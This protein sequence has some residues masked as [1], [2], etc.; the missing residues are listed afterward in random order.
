VWRGLG[1]VR[2]GRLL[3]DVMVD[4]IWFPDECW[5][6]AE[7]LLIM[8][9]SRLWNEGV[10]LAV[11]LRHASRPS[12]K[13]RQEELKPRRFRIILLVTKSPPWAA[14]ERV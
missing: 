7:F 5:T 6:D 2:V 8:Q 14:V 11:L 10:R 12:S 4:V 1:R 13:K 3:G 9:C